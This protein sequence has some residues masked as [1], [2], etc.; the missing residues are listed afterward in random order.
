[1]GKLRWK[2]LSARQNN[3]FGL[4]LPK[5]DNF[6]K[7]LTKILRKKFSP[8]FLY[9]KGHKRLYKR[10]KEKFTLFSKDLYVL[11]STINDIGI[12]PIEKKLFKSAPLDVI[13]TTTSGWSLHVYRSI[14]QKLWEIKIWVASNDKFCT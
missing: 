11:L 4:I 5:F 9:K 14:R 13:L 8:V 1:M 2:L 3:I 6:G 10:K 7:I 12:H